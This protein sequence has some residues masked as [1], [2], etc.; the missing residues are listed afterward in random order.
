[1]T[2]RAKKM[3][4]TEGACFFLPLDKGGF[5][6]GII[7]R[8]S[9]N[10]QLYAYFF[11]PRLTLAEG[12]FEGISADGAVLSGICGDLGLTKG[13]WILAGQLPEWRRERWPLPPLYREDVEAQKAWRS[14]YNDTNLQFVREESVPFRHPVH[15][16]QP[17]DRMMGYGAAATMLDTLLA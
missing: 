3:Y 15:A 8:V 7:T 13:E 12:S 17:Y 1:M 10:G 16:K 11:G 4:Y 6:R 14:Y 2:K 5:A 9:G